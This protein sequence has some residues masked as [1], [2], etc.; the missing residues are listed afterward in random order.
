MA[1][2]LFC[3]Q[4]RLVWQMYVTWRYL[5]NMV[6]QKQ[7]IRH[8]WYKWWLKVK[9]YFNNKR[10]NYREETKVSY[11]G[12]KRVIKR[13]NHRWYTMDLTEI[14]SSGRYDKGYKFS[15]VHYRNK[16]Q[17]IHYKIEQSVERSMSLSSDEKENVR[18]WNNT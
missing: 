6:Q 16:E 2:D 9:S 12:R 10:F 7:Y 18:L 8:S 13:W 17:H 15:Y 3:E 14:Q 5:I 11:Q 1:W 4:K